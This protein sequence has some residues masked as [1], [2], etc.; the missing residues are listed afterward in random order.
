M[1]SLLRR[2][3]ERWS[4]RGMLTITVG[5]ATGRAE[6]MVQ[7]LRGKIPPCVTAALVRSWLNGWCTARRF[8]QGR[9][10]CWLSEECSGDDSIEHYARCDWSWHMAKRRLKVEQS[11]RNIGR[12]LMLE[13]SVQDDPAML[14]LNLYAVYNAVNH[15]RSSGQRGRENAAYHRISALYTQAALLHT[16]LA[17]RMRSLR[18]Q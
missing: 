6:R 3:L 14:A 4:N 5:S 1:N 18:R 15:F 16:G 7:Q 11:P 12:F 13:T 17:R 10:K 2:R 8:Q 9:G